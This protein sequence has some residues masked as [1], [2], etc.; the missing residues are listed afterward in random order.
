M[1]LRRAEK[2]FNYITVSAAFS[3]DNAYIAY[4]PGQTLFLKH[5]LLTPFSFTKVSIS[6]DFII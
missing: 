5:N 2:I 6:V 4:R 3:P 1:A